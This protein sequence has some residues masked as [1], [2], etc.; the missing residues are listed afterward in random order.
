MNKLEVGMFIR[1]KSGL[2][3]KYTGFEKDE[4]DDE[5][6]KYNF[7]GKIY[8]YYEYYNDYVYEEDFEYWFENSVV[9]TSHNITDLI[10]VGDYVNGY[11]ITL[12]HET[13]NVLYAEDERGYLIKSFGEEDI[14]FVVTKQQFSSIE[15]RLGE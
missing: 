3:A 11:K 14:K 1:T 15:Y 6:N 9:K 10:E 13:Y 4:N 8:W 12:I 5:Y 7:D 2:I